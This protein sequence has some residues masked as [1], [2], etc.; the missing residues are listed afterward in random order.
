MD[1]T[2]TKQAWRWCIAGNIVKSHEDENGVTRY[3]TKAFSGGT[4]VYYFGYC[5]GCRFGKMIGVIGKN[6]FGR[7]A[8]EDVYV[9]HIENVRVQ[10]VFTPRVLSIIGSAEWMDGYI[11]WNQTPEDKAE[12][13]NCAEHWGS[14]VREDE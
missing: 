10:Q 8:F 13:Q 11:C 7:W 3:G 9:E 1:D 14:Y 12:A 5:S 6:R 2:K 4:K